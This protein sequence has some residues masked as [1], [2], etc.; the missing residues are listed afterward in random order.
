MAKLHAFISERETLK[1]LQDYA[2][3]KQLGDDSVTKGNI[4]TAH[5]KY[6]NGGT[7][8]YLVVQLA[9]NSHENAFADLDKLANS[10]DVNTQ[11]IVLGDID[12]L[13]F[14]KQLITMGVTEYLLLPLKEHH[15]ERLLSHKKEDTA[16]QVAT[17][18]KKECKIV[19]VISTRG[20][21]GGSTITVNLAEILA[22]KGHTTAI[23]DLDP[24]FGTIPLML[25]VEPSRGLVDALEKPE[26]IDHLFLDRVMT[27]VTDKLFVIGAEKSLH[28]IHEVNEKAAETILNLLRARFDFVIVDVP[29]VEAYDFYVLQH[30][31]DI[32]VTEL[33]IPGLRDT[34]RIHDLINEK[35]GNKKIT[36][37]AN[38]VGLNKKYETPV[39]DFEQG[40]GRKIDFQ[41]PFEQEVYGFSNAGKTLADEHK[42]GKF[43]SAINSLAGKFLED[44]QAS[45]QEG[46][47]KIGLLNKLLSKK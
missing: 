37:V 40:L 26:R 5:E 15:I 14:Y 27:K 12:E 13:S 31:E 39:K 11:V 20:G 33:S 10:C 1:A 47:P 17:E 8:E 2:A 9:D 22:K 35:L 7:P 32:L 3:Q 30:A 16:K 28:E 41:V 24:S 4:R 29:R 19:S 42:G 23:L 38:K 36:L 25:D 43:I 45:A 44:A 18:N 34:M 6:A 21:V 46:T